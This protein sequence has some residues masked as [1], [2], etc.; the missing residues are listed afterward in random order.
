M[1]RNLVRLAL[2]ALLP[3][4]LVHEFLEATLELLLRQLA[5]RG[6]EALALLVLRDPGHFFQHLVRRLAV[7][8][9]GVLLRVHI[10][11]EAEPDE[12][13]DRC[14]EVLVRVVPELL[15][16]V[17]PSL[18]R[19]CGSYRTRGGVGS[20]APFSVP[21][22]RAV[23]AVVAPPPPLKCGGGSLDPCSR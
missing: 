7:D 21:R 1:G 5:P 6:C 3:H 12:V 20:P 10:F 23:A 8:V 4:L 15:R 11:E 14:V 22:R 18:L 13:L 2:P 9:Q 19:P 16:V 17:L